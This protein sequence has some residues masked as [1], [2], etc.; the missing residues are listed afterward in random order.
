MHI[1]KISNAPEQ[2]T[3][4]NILGYIAG[5][6]I[7]GKGTV[8]MDTSKVNAFEQAISPTLDNVADQYAALDNNN[9]KAVIDTI[10]KEIKEKM[11]PHRAT[12]FFKKNHISFSHVARIPDFDITDFIN[13]AVA[14]A[15]EK[16][17]EDTKI[18]NTAYNHAL[19]GI[20]N[21]VDRA[22]DQLNTLVPLH[23]LKSLNIF[24]SPC[25]AKILKS[26]PDHA[27][28][29]T[30]L[31]TNTD[32][33]Y[34]AELNAI[35]PEH[36]SQVEALAQTIQDLSVAKNKTSGAQRLGTSFMKPNETAQQTATATLE[37]AYD[38]LQ[39][40]AMA[41]TERA[42][43]VHPKQ[44]TP[45]DRLTSVTTMQE[46]F[47]T[48]GALGVIKPA[49]DLDLD[50]FRLI[51]ELPIP[52]LGEVPPINHVL[53]DTLPSNLSK[54]TT[55][56]ARSDSNIRGVVL[57]DSI[58]DS[59]TPETKG[60]ILELT[61][62]SA[63]Q[64]FDPNVIDLLKEIDTV[65]SGNELPHTPIV[66][67]SATGEHPESV[68]TATSSQYAALL[69]DL[70]NAPSRDADIQSSTGNRSLDEEA[71]ETLLSNLNKYAAGNS[72]ESGQPK[73]PL[74]Q[75][76]DEAI[77]ETGKHDK[78]RPESKNKLTD[79]FTRIG[80]KSPVNLDS[81]KPLLKEAFKGETLVHHSR[82]KQDYHRTPGWKNELDSIIERTTA[83]TPNKPPT[84]EITE[85]SKQLMKQ[86]IKDSGK[87]PRGGC[88]EDLE[89]YFARKMVTA[90]YNK[91]DAL[92]KE[93]QESIKSNL[94]GLL[95]GNTVIKASRHH[96]QESHRVNGWHKSI[97]DFVK[98]ESK[99]V[100]QERSK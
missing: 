77:D 63:R 64:S 81:V 52:P 29:M 57:S 87:F 34:V 71:V 11:N 13:N 54:L 43:T 44:Y 92:T 68:G 59:F 12:V 88:R 39:S 93:R 73:E 66:P 48:P 33:S 65:G 49:L 17:A 60:L 40:K 83:S 8:S 23:T 26:R 22:V 36:L 58:I 19:N 95:K 61:T 72:P 98:S 27:G 51:V 5:N 1:T 86:A 80:R 85:I 90:F 18:L 69:K 6:V 91:P 56:S 24:G 62:K 100:A 96:A 41:F 76:M 10:A 74:A 35:L 28:D 20:Q 16:Q 97:H 75:I 25:T 53:A 67:A 38:E 45:E 21:S 94:T 55:E 2:L 4:E 9:K 46:Y 47:I 78:L 84:E 89:N 7:P 30:K 15:T 3:A 31:F 50:T 42:I 79:Y 82:S 14:T 37:Q 32:L 70:N 99:E